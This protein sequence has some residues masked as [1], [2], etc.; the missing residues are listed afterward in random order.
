MFS[1]RILSRKTQAD[2]AFGEWIET[3]LFVKYILISTGLFMPLFFFLWARMWRTVSGSSD[4]LHPQA[5]I[6]YRHVFSAQTPPSLPLLCDKDHIIK[7]QKR[8]SNFRAGGIFPCAGHLSTRDLCRRSLYRLYKN[9]RENPCSSI[10][11]RMN[12]GRD[13]KGFTWSWLT[14]QSQLRVFCIVWKPAI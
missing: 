2:Y 9:N 14:P 8:L 1:E 7:Q 11:K 6:N 5:V 12:G 13:K 3:I 10:P 4:L